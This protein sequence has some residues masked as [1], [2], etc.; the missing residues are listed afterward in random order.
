M[1]CLVCTSTLELGIDVPQVASVAQI[2][3]PPA[4]SSLKQ[5]AGRSGRG[6]AQGRLHL[7]CP[8]PAL[9]SRASLVQR[10]RPQ[11]V[12]AIAMVEL[13]QE[14]WL[15]PPQTGLPHLSTLVHQV[16]S[17]LLQTSGAGPREMWTLLCERGAFRAVDWPLFKRLLSQ[18]KA[19]GLVRQEEDAPTV[20][21]DVAGAKIATHYSF[22][23]I[24]ETPRE[25]QLVADGKKLGTLPR[26]LPTLPKDLLLFAGRRWQVVAVDTA[27]HVLEV[28]PSKAGAAPD[29]G[30][31]VAPVHDAVRQ[32]MRALYLASHMPDFCDEV[33]ARLLADARTAFA[34]VQLGATPLVQDGVDT[35]LFHWMGDRTGATL[36]LQLA[37]HDLRAMDEGVCLRVAGTDRTSL[38]GTLRVIAQAPCPDPVALAQAVPNKRAEKYDE[39]L[40]QELLSIEY[41]HR[42]LDVAGALAATLAICAPA[43]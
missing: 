14:G 13:M 17:L 19:V 25:W 26:I 40:G 7:Y 34:S 9:D 42:M 43:H 30:G 12:Q 32:K 37:A 28:K 6:D 39:F 8:E 41:V 31:S 23:V 27:R 3:P 38:E 29:F 36:R 15:E 35:L 11:L 21:L 18:L 5:R 22:P 33:A 10:L 16:L 24:F 20:R 4:V 2:G 1:L